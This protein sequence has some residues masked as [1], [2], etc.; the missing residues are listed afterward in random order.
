MINSFSADAGVAIITMPSPPPPHADAGV[1]TCINKF[2]PMQVFPQ[3]KYAT[4]QPLR[5][6]CVVFSPAAQ[7]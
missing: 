1:F 5:R 2:P 7:H 6:R 4:P 3:M